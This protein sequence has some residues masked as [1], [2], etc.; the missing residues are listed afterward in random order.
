MSLLD[1]VRDSTRGL[2]ADA[3]LPALRRG[4][5]DDIEEITDVAALSDRSAVA[6]VRL[7]DGRDIFVPMV[8]AARD[9]SAR[10]RGTQPDR[11]WRRAE[12]ADAISMS[13]LGAP[14]PLRVDHINPLP[15]L[16]PQRE[17]GLDVDMTNDV[18]IVDDAVVA[19]WQ[20][21]R[22]PD[23]IVGQRVVAHLS[24]AGF[25]DMPEPFATVTWNDDVVLTATRFLPEAADGWDWMLDE[26]LRMLAHGGASPSWPAEIGSLT[27]RMHAAA[28]RPTPVIDRPVARA[29]LLDLAQHYQALLDTALDPEL[30]TAV[31][32][33][34]ARFTEAI[35]VLAGTQDAEV[36]PLHR[37][38][39][40]GQFLRWRGGIAICDFD[41]N[42]AFRAE[43]QDMRGPTAYDVAGMLRGFDHV[44]I[45][46]AN[47]AGA[48]DA[49]DHARAW[50]RD[51]RRQALDAYLA[52]PGLPP[53]DTTILGAL[54]SL[55]PLHEAV[56]AAT[57]LP[58]WRYVPLAVLNGGW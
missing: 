35:D 27:A 30:Q 51:A 8:L 11:A 58:R 57:Y 5:D 4:H 31:Q 54:E 26:V 47:R 38:L 19:K 12:P 23:A 32:R 29:P 20:L 13:A 28:A 55:S 10:P 7:V 9:G 48:S 6:A 14:P 45:A 17:R 46:A 15:M 43:E 52:E 40:P 36:V 39:H 49:L 41:G 1:Q 53:L 3:L 34:R 18:R 2:K 25:T 21:L 50:A 22:Q 42:P 37:D 56:Y 33:W 16:D 44:A 24:A